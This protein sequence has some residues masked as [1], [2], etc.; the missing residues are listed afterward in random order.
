[1]NSS[2]EKIKIKLLL[3]YILNISDFIFTIFLINTEMF[4][5]GNFLMTS[6]VENPLKG[7]I[8]KVVIIGL[9]LFFLG[10]LFRYANKLELYHINYI[11]LLGL[12]LYTSVNILHVF[13]T[14]L[15]VVSKNI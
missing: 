2:Y 4:Y 14:I 3:I 5:E 15:Y 6:F 8:L 10:I 7:F 11:V 12:T 13:Y 1:M 9:V